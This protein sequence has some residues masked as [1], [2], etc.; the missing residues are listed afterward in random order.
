MKSA[1]MLVVVNNSFG[2][3]MIVNW[4]IQTEVSIVPFSCKQTWTDK[5]QCESG[6]YVKTMQ[7]VFSPGEFYL[8][9]SNGFILF[10]KQKSVFLWVHAKLI[11]VFNLTLHLCIII[12]KCQYN[13]IT[14]LRN[15]N[16][17]SE[18]MQPEQKLKQY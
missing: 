4:Y 3:A 9:E 7:E 2:F 12:G 16:G 13:N 17:R 1:S 11:R 14:S 6:E 10:L 15:K 5:K 8:G 18:T